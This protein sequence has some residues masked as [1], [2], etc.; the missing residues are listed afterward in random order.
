MHIE[1]VILNTRDSVVL[2]LVLKL[3]PVNI[4]LNVFAIFLSQEPMGKT[5]TFYF[6]KVTV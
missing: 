3:I 5:Q 2:Y 6:T 1:E 4:D